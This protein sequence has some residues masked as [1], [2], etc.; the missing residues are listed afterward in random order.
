MTPE[1]IMGLAQNSIYLTLLVLAPVLG[2]ALVVGLIV[3]ILQ[4]V[5]QIQE[6]TLSFAPKIIAVFVGLLIFG[7][8]MLTHLI[9]FTHNILANLTSY[10]G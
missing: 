10:I 6:Q 2:I 4:T 7:P 5:T 8:W 1:S 3:S 9:D